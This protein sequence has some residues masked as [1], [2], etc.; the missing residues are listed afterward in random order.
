MHF[1]HIGVS[2]VHTGW[3]NCYEEFLRTFLIKWIFSITKLHSFG[4]LRLISFYTD[5]MHPPSNA[6]SASKASSLVKRVL[7]QTLG[8]PCHS[9]AS[10]PIPVYPLV[11][12]I[13]CRYHAISI[14]YYS[15]I[16]WFVQLQNHLRAAPL[17]GDDNELWARLSHANGW[18][19]FSTC[20]SHRTD[21]SVN[22]T[23]NLFPCIRRP[24]KIYLVFFVPQILDGGVVFY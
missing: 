8:F 12:I 3:L 10:L 19:N 4:V 23:Q 7:W 15:F 9:N 13:I 24:L 5:Y 2:C 18:R 16:F 14:L 17:W 20:F 11:L 22:I 6:I 1:A 21:L